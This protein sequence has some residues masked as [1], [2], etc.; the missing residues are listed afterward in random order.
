M[1]KDAWLEYG[2]LGTRVLS[3]EDIERALARLERFWRNRMEWDQLYMP[4][5]RSARVHIAPNKR[6]IPGLRL[7]ERLDETYAA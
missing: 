7:G 3:H 5:E 4:R 2:S 6:A 1:R